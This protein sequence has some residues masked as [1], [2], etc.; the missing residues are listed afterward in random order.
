MKESKNDMNLMK[1]RFWWRQLQKAQREEFMASVNVSWGMIKA[2]VARGANAHRSA[3]SETAAEIERAAR[4]FS[5]KYPDKLPL[6]TRADLS[7]VCAE[8]PFYRSGRTL[9]M[10]MLDD[11]YERRIAQERIDKGRDTDGTAAA[12]LAEPVF[13]QREPGERVGVPGRP[14]KNPEM[15]Q[16]EAIER[17]KIAEV[18]YKR[19]RGRPR[20]NPLPPVKE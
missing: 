3:R 4:P 19:P 7:R 1:F 18:G 6:L 10:R 15:T 8:C 14:R 20:K 16:R 5:R 2:I 11:Y 12:R 13:Q 9:E 17:A